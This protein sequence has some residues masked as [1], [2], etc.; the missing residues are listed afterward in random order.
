MTAF[1]GSRSLVDTLVP[2]GRVQRY[3]WYVALAV[4][5]TF[6]LT[7]SA[8][9]K[10]PMWP[11]DASLQTLAIAAIAATYGMRLGTATVVLYLLEGAFG[12]P[13]FQGTPER[14]IGLAYMMGSTG[15]YLAGY[16]AMAAIIGWGADRGWDRN[17]FK[18]FGVMLVA[19]VVMLGLGALW[20]AHLFGADKAFAYGVGPF[21][22]TDLVKIAIAACIVPALWRGL[23]RLRV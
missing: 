14:G 19:E 13:V 16:V 23:R 7:V 1:A 20:L 10:V 9:I 4:L 8:K 3:V 2:E 22:V 21:I 5:G 12:M 11:V 17:P 6:I 15:G 18:L